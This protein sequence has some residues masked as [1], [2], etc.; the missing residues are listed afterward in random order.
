[1]L[2]IADTHEFLASHVWGMCVTPN[3]THRPTCKEEDNI[4]IQSDTADRAAIPWYSESLS[5]ILILCDQVHMILNLCELF[6][7]SLMV[8]MYTIW[9]YSRADNGSNRERLD[10]SM[11]FG[12]VTPA[13]LL[14]NFRRVAQKSEWIFFV[15]IAFY[16]TMATQETS[17]NK[18]GDLMRSKWKKTFKNWYTRK[19]HHP[20]K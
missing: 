1:M 10:K 5:H 12:T 20:L 13:I 16:V 17:I 11:K 19:I 18:I 2:H 6:W 7:G 8:T 9:W 4:R 14:N 15:K 3:D